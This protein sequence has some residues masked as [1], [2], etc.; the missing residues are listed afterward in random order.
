MKT[1]LQKYMRDCLGVSRRKAEDLIKN[2]R[3][4]VDAQVA[5]LGTVIDSDIDK[6]FVDSKEL[7]LHSKPIYIM[8]NKPTGF[9]TT[10]FD[11]Q[12]RK[13]VY[14][15]LPK[16]FKELFPVG[17]LDYD[18]EGLLLLTNDG[19]FTYKLTHPKFEI[20]KEYEVVLDKKVSYKQIS[21]IEQGVKSALINTAPAKV[22]VLN[23]KKLNLI[24]HEGQKR[25]IKLIFRVFGIEV[26]SLK[27][28]R[29][30]K[31]YLGNLPIGKWR[32]LDSIEVNLLK[33]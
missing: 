1:R 17:R 9:V 5:K 13:T 30:K 10:R 26:Q 2:G 12:M 4:T 6:V 24:I 15:L 21:Q 8:L 23:D 27:R 22:K 28:V 33:N 19:D 32:H 18:T 3:V 7:K 14:D 11:P 31:L 16:N 29:I 25:E 20:E